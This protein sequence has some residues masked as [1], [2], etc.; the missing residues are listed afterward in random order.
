MYQLLIPPKSPPESWKVIS[1]KQLRISISL[2]ASID[3]TLN[4]LFSDPMRIGD[5]GGDNDDDDDDGDGDNDN[6]GDDDDGGT[7]DATS[8]AD[9]TDDGCATGEMQ[10]VSRL[11]TT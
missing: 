2:F 9:K 7:V 1:K 4:C 8:A 3:S 6:D 10:H 5:D 11:F